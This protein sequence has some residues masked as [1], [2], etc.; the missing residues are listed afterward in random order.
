[1][2]RVVGKELLEL[3]VELGGERLV[4]SDDERGPAH[5]RDHVGDGEGLARAGDAE[6]GLE[7]VAA[8]QPVNQLADRLRLIAGRLE[9]GAELEQALVARRLGHTAPEL[10]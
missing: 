6:Q 3:A 10:S 4:V 2:D 9:L 5:L 8:L 1:M 7:A